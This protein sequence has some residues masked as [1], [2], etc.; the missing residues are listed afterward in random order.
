MKPWLSVGAKVVCVDASPRGLRLR[1][2]R[3]LTEGT[4][5]V[6]D[7]IT[8]QGGVNVSGIDAQKFPF[9]GR[10]AWASDRFRPLIDTTSQV[11]EMQALMRRAVETRK[12]DA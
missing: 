1:H 9:G 12:V 7:E 8:L 4:V 11:S 3:W 2:T 6:V 10:Y 5:Y